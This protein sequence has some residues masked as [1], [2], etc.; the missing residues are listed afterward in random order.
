MY[1][2]WENVIFADEQTENRNEMHT[3]TIAVEDK[4]VM[5]GL[6]KVLKSMKG[7]TIMESTQTKTTKKK[8]SYQRA[9]DDLEKGNVSCYENVDE[10]LKDLGI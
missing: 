3:I 1:Y 10:L 9:L 4:S 6:R 8:T 2:V 7:V 5:S